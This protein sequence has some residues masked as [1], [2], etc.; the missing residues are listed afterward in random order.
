[1]KLKLSFLV[2]V[3]LLAARAYSEEQ[4][5]AME[6]KNINPQIE[7]LEDVSKTPPNLK[8]VVE[9]IKVS[10]I[11]GTRAWSYFDK[12]ENA[13]VSIEAETVSPA[14]L[15][16][17]Q[18]AP[19]VDANAVIELEFEKEPDSYEVYIRGPKHRMKG[20]YSEVVLDESTGK[21]VY[22][23][24]AAWEQRTTDYVFSLSVE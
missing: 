19:S 2:G 6:V 17:N 3:L 9:G 8:V 18:K 10:A 14:E 5:T 12:E 13:M 4:E 16:E 15:A 20:P 23:F 1:M 7:D 11:L 24:A 22:E 21:M